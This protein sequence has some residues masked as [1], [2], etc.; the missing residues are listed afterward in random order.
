MLRT[1]VA[2]SHFMYV[3]ITLACMWWGM[4][5]IAG[6]TLWNDLV[7]R[8]GGTVWVEAS[9][10]IVEYRGREAVQVSAVDITERLESEQKRRELGE[11]ARRQKNST[12]FVYAMRG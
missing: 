12:L 3:P 5:G 4:R 2:Y 6:E 7:R 10:S 11:L 1:D 8:D 9:S